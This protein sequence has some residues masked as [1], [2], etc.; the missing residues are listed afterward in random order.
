[1]EFVFLYFLYGQRK[2]YVLKRYFNLTNRKSK[3]FQ[4]SG[5]HRTKSAG[6]LQDRH[7]LVIEDD[8]HYSVAILATLKQK[9]IPSPK[10]T[11]SNA[12]CSTLSASEINCR[13]T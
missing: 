6:R 8:E 13:A 11:N 2:F 12:V 5:F 9:N 3:E 7:F 10:V 1:V 4:K